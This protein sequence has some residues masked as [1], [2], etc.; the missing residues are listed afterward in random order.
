HTPAQGRRAG[1]LRPPDR[2]AGPAPDPPQPREPPL[3]PHET[4]AH[5]PPAGARGGARGGPPRRDEDNRLGGI[6]MGRTYTGSPDGRG[7]RVAIAASRFNR[8]GTDPLGA[9]AVEGG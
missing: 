7:R 3:S 6:T 4:R 5:G 9:G 2:G 1:R 8:L